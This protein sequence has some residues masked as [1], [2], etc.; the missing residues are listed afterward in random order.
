MRIIILVFC[1][2]ISSAIYAQGFHAYKLEK[3]RTD[4]LFPYNHL[5][6]TI[7][8]NNVVVELDEDKLS[9]YHPKLQEFYFYENLSM[10]DKDSIFMSNSIFV[11][12]NSN[13]GRFIYFYNKY[14]NSRTIL[15]SY[16]DMYLK[17]YLK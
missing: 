5:D 16:D 2:I 14:N 13:S 1:F 11:D 15:L 3:G 8:L 9:I 17:Y 6:S 10:L 4:S 7:S 12:L